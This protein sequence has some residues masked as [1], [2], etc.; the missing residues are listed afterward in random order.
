MYIALDCETG[1]IGLDKSLLTFYFQILNKDFKPVDELY[2]FLKP[3]DGI[4]RITCE[5]MIINKIDLVEHDKIA[6]TY[7]QAGSQLY[8][9]LKIN[10]A[11]KDNRYIPVGHGMSGDLQQIWDKLISRDTWETFVSYRR[12]DTSVVCQF[13]RTCGIFPD[14]ISGSLESLIDYFKLPKG[15]LHD[16]KYDTLQTVEILKRL[17]FKIQSLQSTENPIGSSFNTQSLEKVN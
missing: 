7:K 2:L 3:N 5:S 10:Y 16:A 4:Y 1:G 9:F 15:S 12:L 11:G 17:I 8:N 6:I 14:T 13:L